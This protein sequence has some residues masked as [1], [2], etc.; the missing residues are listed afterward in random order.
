MK[1]SLSDFLMFAARKPALAE[2][3]AKLA[4]R[5][6]FKIIDELGDRE[7]GRIVGGMLSAP[8]QGGSRTLAFP[9]VS[10]APS[11]GGPV[12]IPYPNLGGAKPDASS[13]KTQ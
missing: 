7:L 11:P 6:G 2:E 3:L 13:K 1:G 5:H 12:P 8:R 9:D 4:A 10:R